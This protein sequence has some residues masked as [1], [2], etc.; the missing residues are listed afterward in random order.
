MSDTDDDDGGRDS[1]RAGVPPLPSAKPGAPKPTHEETHV[2][3][4]V[5][6]L[7]GAKHPTPPP[8]GPTPGKTDQPPPAAPP[9]DN[10][11]ND[12][13]T[14]L[15]SDD[16]DLEETVFEVRSPFSLVRVKPPGHAAPITLSGSSY[17]LGRSRTC[18][19]QLFS[20]SS[21]RQHAKLLSRAG[22]WVL[23]PIENHIVIANGDLVRGEIQ[24]VHKMR[25]QLGDDELLF[26]DERKAA[27]AT[28]TGGAMPGP[29]R[30]G[31]PRWAA[32]AMIAVAVL[33]VAGGLLWWWSAM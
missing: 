23:Q 30:R 19:I 5:P 14:R 15:R 13:A 2:G 6:V 1:T 25:L 9:A 7:P 32:L 8:P 22:A 27:T 21:H 4:S 31:L 18:D 26:F 29:G 28:R 24:V 3:G 33:V 16:E 10:L 17:I 11:K 20:A 12:E